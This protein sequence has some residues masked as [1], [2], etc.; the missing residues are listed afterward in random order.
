MTPLRVL[1]VD[2]HPIF[3]DGL[4]TAL[5]DDTIELVG[6]AANGTEAIEL[7]TDIAPDVILMDLQMPGQSGIDATR[8]ITSAQPSIA[9]LI[10]T[11]TDDTEAVFAAIRAGARG[12]LLKGADRQELLRAVHG[13]A[14]GEAIFGP[15]IAEQLLGAFATEHSP[16][17]PLPVLTDRERDV[18]ALLADGYTNTAIAGKLFVSPKTVR[19]HVS[20][21]LTKLQVT[22]RHEAARLA[23]EAGLRDKPT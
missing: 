5:H 13:I 15:G 20:N 2:D 9:V 16:S 22:D 3:R 14:S 12:Y 19:N 10:L 23:R 6:E 17:P 4:R 18:I 11:M 8:A 7:A 1:I 21:I